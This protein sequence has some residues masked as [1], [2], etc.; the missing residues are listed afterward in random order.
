MASQYSFDYIAQ[1][2]AIK[3]FDNKNTKSDSNAAITE[4]NEKQ[5][6]RLQLITQ[7]MLVAFSNK[8]TPAIDGFTDKPVVQ[9]DV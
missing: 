8:V 1:Y 2:N 9:C 6:V 3:A 7:G 4:K 5:Y